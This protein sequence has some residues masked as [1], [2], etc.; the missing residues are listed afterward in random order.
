VPKSIWSSARSLPYCVAR[1]STSRLKT[2]IF[3]GIIYSL[4]PI[5]SRLYNARYPID[6]CLSL[7]FPAILTGLTS[8]VCRPRPLLP[9][10][11]GGIMAHCLA[12]LPPGFILDV[13]LRGLS[14]IKEAGSRKYWILSISNGIPL[15]DFQPTSESSRPSP[16]NRCGRSFNQVLARCAREKIHS[17]P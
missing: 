10:H 4:F 14:P 7:R 2:A 3:L 15:L 5:V 9:R 8:L 17:V 13:P 1:L 16:G 6:T 12:V 11:S